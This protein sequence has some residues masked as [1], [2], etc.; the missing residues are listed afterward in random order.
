ME[1]EDWKFKMYAKVRL[2]QRKLHLEAQSGQ[3][4]LKISNP[5]KRP[6]YPAFQNNLT[7]YN[8]RCLSGMG[9]WDGLSSY[10]QPGLDN[11]R[12][13]KTWFDALDQIAAH[14]IL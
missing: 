5:N 7:Q 14:Y 3:S 8:Q 9:S 13:L 11:W 4:P 2:S 10:Q 12:K 1:G 6:W